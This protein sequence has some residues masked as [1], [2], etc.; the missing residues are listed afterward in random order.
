MIKRGTYT[1]DEA[2]PTS[3]ILVLAPTGATKL[4]PLAFYDID[5]NSH[6]WDSW[7]LVNGLMKV[8]FGV[9]LVSGDLEYEYQVEGDDPIVVDG[10]GNQV[11]IVINQY[12]GVATDPVS[13]P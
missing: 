3:T 2:S 10:D 7:D 4:R 12:G 1:V 9:D 5:G 11:S 8:S 13:F 6:E